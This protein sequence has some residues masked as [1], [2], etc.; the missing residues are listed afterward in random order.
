MYNDLVSIIIPVY[1]EERCLSKCINSIIAQS[2]TKWELI[3][4]NDGSNDNSGL[5]CDQYAELDTRI[6]VIHTENKGPSRARNIALDNATGKY[7]CFIDSD[8]W[9]EMRY[10]EHLLQAATFSHSLVIAGYIKESTDKIERKCYNFCIYSQNNFNKLFNDI[11]LY[12][13]GFAWAKLF[14][15]TLIDQKNIRFNEKIKFSEDLVFTLTYLLYA[16]QAI[17]IEHSDYHYVNINNKSLSHKYHS[18]ET[19]YHGYRAF[20]DVLC[21]H[22]H[23]HNF[24]KL[25]L[26][27]TKKWLAYFALRTIKSTYR[28]KYNYIN[29]NDRVNLLKSSFQ[30][31]DKLLLADV[32]DYLPVFD[33]T[34]CILFINNRIILLD[35]IISIVY[36]LRNIKYIER[37]YNTLNNRS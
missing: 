36:F 30:K 4:V 12:H 20:Y 19:E 25:D 10:V 34:I 26:L 6:K 28:P 18:F 22:E 2:H 8:D 32:K 3:L 35:I 33:K 11:K 1:D 7:V 23:T 31:N 15:K 5:I 9:V 13:N 17:I 16:E 14:E 24:S 27:E 37:I 21:L 29:R